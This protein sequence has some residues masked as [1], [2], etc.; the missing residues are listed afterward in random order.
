[1]PPLYDLP[2]NCFVYQHKNCSHFEGHLLAVHVVLGKVLDVLVQVARSCAGDGRA[3]DGRAAGTVVAKALVRRY[4]LA[5]L[6]ESLYFLFF[7]FGKGVITITT[8][9]R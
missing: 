3:D 2:A 6:L 7:V 9:S 8:A 4:Q 5:Q 1:M